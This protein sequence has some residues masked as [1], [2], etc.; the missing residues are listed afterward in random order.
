[1]S[2][3]PRALLAL[4]VAGVAAL[5]VAGCGSSSNS[6]T[7]TE[8]TTTAPSTSTAPSTTPAATTLQLKADQSQLAFDTTSLTAPAGE[9]TIVLT[10]PSSIPHNVEVEGNGV[11]A[12][13]SDTISD[14]KTTELKVTLQPGTY[15]F[16][17]AVD[18]HRGAGM[19]GTLTIT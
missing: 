15:E 2:K 13:P 3:R 9:V 16:Y 17:C 18:G 12:G 6:E 1:M 19:E 4:A 11:E 10:N 7:T 14:G 8:S 5:G